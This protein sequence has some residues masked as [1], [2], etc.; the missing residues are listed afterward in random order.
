MRVV[1]SRLAGFTPA[2]PGG[3]WPYNPIT[4]GMGD[5]VK[6]RYSLPQNPVVPGLAGMSAGCCGADCSCGPCSGGMGDLTS[7]WDSAVNQVETAT[8]DVTSGNFTAAWTDLN[9]GS[10]PG[11]GFLLVVGGLAAISIFA[12]GMKKR[13]RR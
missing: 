6:G 11:P 1:R 12:G 10:F 13:G 9:G 7:W 4:G 3:A 8:T 5:F 2:L